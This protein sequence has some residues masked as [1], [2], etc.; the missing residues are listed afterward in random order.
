MTQ[1]PI[2]EKIENQTCFIKKQWFKNVETI[3]L[4]TDQKFVKKLNDKQYKSICDKF[5]VKEIS[6]N[7]SGYTT[8]IYSILNKK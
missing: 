3:L 6:V 4:D 8:R 7:F 5:V 1:K 2:T